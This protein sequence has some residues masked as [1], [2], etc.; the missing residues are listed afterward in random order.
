LQYKLYYSAYVDYASYIS[1]MEHTLFY[2]PLSR[3]MVNSNTAA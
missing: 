3:E 1:I 2:L